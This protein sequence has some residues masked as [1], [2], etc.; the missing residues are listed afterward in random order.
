MITKLHVISMQT[1]MR[2]CFCA[3]ASLHFLKDFFF[4]NLMQFCSLCLWGPTDPK[5]H[6]TSLNSLIHPL[7]RP[8][9][10]RI[11]RCGNSR[12]CRKEEMKRD[13]PNMA[14]P[15]AISCTI[16]PWE[17]RH[18]MFNMPG[19]SALHIAMLRYVHTEMKRTLRTPVGHD[20]WVS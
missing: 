6:D 2:E 20:G 1:C 14:K 8:R 13:R 10:R 18:L 11:V 5:C 7:T 12:N 16:E 17:W 9:Q 3:N 4:S 19:S 15:L